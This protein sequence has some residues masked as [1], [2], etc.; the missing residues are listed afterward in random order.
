M[1]TAT[2]PQT[3][4]LNRFQF[5][6]VLDRNT[7]V[8][9][10]HE[11][12]GGKGKRIQLE[13]HE[14]LV[15][16]IREKIRL[17]TG[18]FAIVLNPFDAQRNDI[19]VGEREVREGPTEFALHPGE[20]LEGG[21]A[22]SEFVLTDS[23]ALLLRAEKE[24]PHPLNANATIPPGTK[25]L[26]KGPRRFIPHKHVKIL[27]Q[28]TSLS[29]SEHQGVFV[30]NDDTGNVR[31]VR[32][33]TDFFLAHNESF[34]SKVL[35]EEEEEALGFAEQDSGSGSRVLAA[36]PRERKHDHDAVVI[37]LEDNE[38]ICL[39]DG[40]RRRVEFGPKEIFL[41]PNERPKVLCISGDVPVRPNVLRIAKLSL[42]PDFIRD[43]LTVRTK[44]NALLTIEATFRWQ[45]RVDRDQPQ[46]LFALKDFVGFAAQT[47]S[48]EIR[49][50]AAQHD[51]ER[52]H[53]G[54]ALIVKQ[55][56]FGTNTERVFEQNGLVI[57]GVDVESVTPDDK[58]IATKL[59]QTI[60]TTVDIVTRRQQE[61]AQLE[62]E[63]RLI[64]GK[65]KNEEERKRLIALEV[66]NDRT[67]LLEMTRAKV[68]AQKLESDAEADAI[69]TRADAEAE[70]ERKKRTA[71]A[72]V[73]AQA[74]R[75]RAEVF[76][77]PGGEQLIALER[78]S[79]LK[80]TD[81]LVIPTDT[82]LVLGLDKVISAD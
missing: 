67:K 31:L 4:L 62:S 81:K 75:D 35:T 56:I 33:P 17:S 19:A 79:A 7:G 26:L 52:F 11:G 48:S 2:Q 28:R 70:A 36:T 40:D 66:E 53:S 12:A 41:D 57:L 23:Q 44:D 63:R 1:N 6:H 34:W 20:E 61:E 24:C 54:A 60:K 8:L 25:I 50:A 65:V 9:V 15:G 21:K 42:G 10:L 5:C 37:E 59:T 69:R 43:K 47:L 77:G 68:D 78:A 49:E 39:F 82:K 64:S 13:S 30:Q 18:Q 14:E 74:L 16:G 71:T 3:I 76:A 38:A 46:Q 29:L 72:D 45:F 51:F 73:A 32:G 55:A 27:E 22:H 80:A 58:E